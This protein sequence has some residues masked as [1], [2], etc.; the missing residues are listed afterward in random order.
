MNQTDDIFGA[1]HK[2]KKQQ[3]Y[4]KNI[5]LRRVFNNPQQQDDI[6]AP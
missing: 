5:A 3:N 1:K 6:Q 2:L 4:H